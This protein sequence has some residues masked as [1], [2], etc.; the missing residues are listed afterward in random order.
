MKFLR[1]LVPLILV[2]ASATLAAYL[3]RSRPEPPRRPTMPV[4]TAVDATR[5]QLKN[6]TVIVT[7]QGTVRPKTEST[8]I[9]EVSG[10]ILAISPAFRPGGFFEEHDVLLTIDPKDYEAAAVVAEATLAQMEAAL[11]IEKAQGQQALEN[12]NRLGNG[13]EPSPLVLR[14]PQLM[15]ASAAVASAKARLEQA[16][17][18][19]KR[20]KITAPYA[21]R[22]LEK[23]AD[24]GQYVTPG[25]ILASIYAVDY[26][27]I[28][29]PLSNEQLQFVDIPEQFRGDRTTEPPPG[30]RVLLHS[31]IG[32]SQVTWEGT[33][34]RAEGAMDTR[35]R[36][37]FVVAQVEDPYGR[38]DSNKP[39]LKIGSYVEAQIIGRT[40]TNVFVIPRSAVRLGN[41]IL[42]ITETN[43]LQRRKIQPIWS[44]ATDLIARQGL[45]PG[46]ILCLTQVPYAANGAPVLP[47]IDGV[48]PE[49]PESQGPN[50][51][52]QTN[53]K[54]QAST[55][56]PQ[57]STPKREGRVPQIQ[58]QF[59]RPSL[60]KSWNSFGIWLLKPFW[61]LSFEPSSWSEIG[62][63][64]SPIW[65][66]SSHP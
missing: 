56:K 41:E 57:A 17:R 64:E 66:R 63:V 47:T 30:P 45:R 62:N 3:I 23:Q 29:L 38:T 5:L 54:S 7:S 15:E 48:P 26:V 55:P 21:G 59:H 24:V 12:W 50:P 65:N 46:E 20:T 4:I 11:E 28:R 40:Q 49:V 33:I 36:Q 27:E 42:I 10:R 13:A 1:F 51:E 37:L 58:T 2:T 18:D 52:S 9:P 34:V 25:T 8:L 44:G 61:T 35:S 31:Q 19:L 22:I 60:L 32:R 39:P 14:K 43:T 53:P 6:H 16:Q